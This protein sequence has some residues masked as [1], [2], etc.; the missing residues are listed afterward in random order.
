ML[1]H[2]DRPADRKAGYKV[3][4]LLTGTIESLRQQTQERVE[5]G[6]IGIDMS[7]DSTGGRRVGVGKD[8]KHIMAMSMTSRLSDFTGKSDKIAVS[9]QNKEAIVFVIKK[10]KDVL[11]KLTNW[12]V[13]LNADPVTQK[14]DAPML[15][16]D[17]EADNASVN[18][19][20]EKEDPTTINRLIREL[21]SVFSKSNYVGFTATP[22]ANVFIDPETTEDMANHDL[23]PEDFIVSLPTPSNYIGASKIFPEDAPY[24]SQLIYIRDCGSTIEDG[25]PFYFKHKKEWDDD[26]PESLTD[27]IYAFYLANAIRDLRGDIKTH[28]ST[29]NQQITMP[30]IS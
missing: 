27:A 2:M 18:T 13:T 6:F 25:K 15:L 5:E 23:F 22:F 24:H 12:L 8:N 10:Q 17:D 30:K 26:L 11:Q 28:R 3:F 21:V 7:A 29:L 20:K 1:P 19:S 9:L 14:I 4:I 16:I